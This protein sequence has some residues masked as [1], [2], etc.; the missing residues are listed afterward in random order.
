MGRWIGTQIWGP[1]GEKL[2]AAALVTVHVRLAAAMAGLA[3]RPFELG[4]VQDRPLALQEVSLVFE[5]GIPRPP[6]RKHPISAALRMLAV[7]S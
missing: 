5:V 7:F 6:G 4:H 1:M 3:Y 2:V